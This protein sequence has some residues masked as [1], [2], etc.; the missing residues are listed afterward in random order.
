M[1]TGRRRSAGSRSRGAVDAAA[2]AVGGGLAT[3]RDVHLAVARKPFA[4][5]RPLPA[6][7]QVSETVRAVHDGVT[8]LVYAAI[9]GALELAGDAAR[10]ATAA[11]PEDRERRSSAW[12]ELATAALNGWAG[13]RLER[14]QNPLAGGMDLRREGMPLAVERAALSAAFP[15]AAPRIV[16][17]VHGLASTETLWWLHAERHYGDARVSHGV[18][19]ERELGYTPLYV[20]YNTG[21]PIAENG[22][23][24]TL[25]LDRLLDEWPLPVEE[26]VLVGHSMGGLVV[27]AAAQHG[28][29]WTRRARH[30]FYLGSPHRGAPL[31]KATNVAAWLLA[32]SDATRPFA[33]VL[34]GRSRGIKDLRFGAVRDED[35]DGGDVDALLDDRSADLPLLEGANHYFLAATVTRD[36]RHPLGM[37]IGD[38]LVRPASAIG[39]ARHVRFPL[40]RRSHVGAVTHLELLNHPAVYEQIRDALTVGSGTS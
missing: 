33:E 7:G 8:E 39:R 6:V 27:R 15:A 25:L 20:R 35:W 3:V 4:A 24:L 37:A 22:R 29:A 19:L 16:V 12:G 1:G 34:N 30:L 23:R 26:V 18:R 38:L 31:E 32:L 28:A 10:I 14:D 21:L 13:D 5:L 17:F 40:A 36:R 11:L 9:G 2:A